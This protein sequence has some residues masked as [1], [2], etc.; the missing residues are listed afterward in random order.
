MPALKDITAYVN[1]AQSSTTYVEPPR[2]ANKFIDYL[3]LFEE[4]RGT[5]GN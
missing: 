5:K 3:Q 2:T 4:L 1:S